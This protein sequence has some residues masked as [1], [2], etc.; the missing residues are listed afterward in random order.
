M[1]KLLLTAL[2]IVGLAGSSAQGAAAAAA[3]FAAKAG[4]FLRKAALPALVG[5][6]MYDA[7]GYLH[8]QA[9]QVDLTGVN[10]KIDAL[11]GAIKPVLQLPFVVQAVADAADARSSTWY[12]KAWRSVVKF[13]GWSDTVLSKI[14]KIMLILSIFGGAQAYA[15][16]QVAKLQPQP[17]SQLQD[18]ENVVVQQPAQSVVLKKH[19]RHRRS[20]IAA[21]A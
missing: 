5:Q 3:G 10:S 15:H 8:P 11:T 21:R 14:Q 13:D 6:V 2:A 16:N 19:R 17:Q 18:Q 20:G 4:S 7:H 9:S 1:K 12:G